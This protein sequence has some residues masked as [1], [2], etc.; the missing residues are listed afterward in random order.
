METKAS[1]REVEEAPLA[2]QDALTAFFLEFAGW[3]LLRIHESQ[4]SLLKVSG[5]SSPGSLVLILTLTLQG[6]V[7]P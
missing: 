3:N 5:I 6:N 4:S 1:G 7:S 2:V